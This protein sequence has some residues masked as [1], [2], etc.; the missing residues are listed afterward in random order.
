M[1]PRWRSERESGVLARMG[2]A[3][4]GRDGDLGGLISLDM[5]VQFP[6]P[7]PQPVR[8]MEGQ[9]FYKPLMGVRFPHRLPS[10]VVR[11]KRLTV[12]N[13]PRKQEWSG[14]DSRLRLHSDQRASVVIAPA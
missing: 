8:S 7:R 14:F 1:A 13:L 3:A 12:A 10:P 2:D 6:P 11:P 4:E 9:R 5:R